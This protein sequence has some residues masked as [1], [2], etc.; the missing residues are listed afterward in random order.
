MLYGRDPILPQDLTCDVKKKQSGYKDIDHYKVELLRVMKEAYAKTIAVKAKDQMDYKRYYDRTQK[1]VEF[2]IGD[3]VWVHFYLPEVG[4]THKLLAKFDGPYKVL[5]KVNSVSYRVTNDKR[6]FIA[7]V[8]RLL[9][10][11]VFK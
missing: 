1:E 6:C 5:E 11:Y 8:Q 4:K 9:P 10:Y 3:L 7:H 2:K